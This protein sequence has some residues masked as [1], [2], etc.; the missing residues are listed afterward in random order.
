MDKK[1]IFS[2]IKNKEKNNSS[3]NCLNN[4]FH[5]TVYIY[6]RG[7]KQGS[8]TVWKRGYQTGFAVF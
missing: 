6:Q 5:R 8:R 7:R 4:S 3:V 1:E 2:K